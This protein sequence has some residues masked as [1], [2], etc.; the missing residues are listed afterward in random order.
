MHVSAHV[1]GPGITGF[2][3]DRLHNTIHIV[4]TTDQGDWRTIR[5]RHFDP[6]QPCVLQCLIARR[7]LHLTMRIMSFGLHL[8]CQQIPHV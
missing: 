5:D 7:Q 2:E 4:Q 6:R 3:C 1:R 8:K